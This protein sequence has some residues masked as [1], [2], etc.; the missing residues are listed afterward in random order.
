MMPEEPNQE[1][2]RTH[3]RGWW[4]P[5]EIVELLQNGKINA[6]EMALL[7][8]ID[9]L[10]SKTRGCFASREYLAEKLGTSP[11]RISRMISHLKKLG[12]VIQTKFDGRV[13]E[14]ETIW[15]RVK[16][17]T[18]PR[19]KPQGGIDENPKGDSGETPRR[20]R[21]DKKSEQESKDCRNQ[22]CD[23]TDKCSDF[24]RRIAEKLWQSVGDETT[25]SR[26]VNCNSKINSW[27]DHVRRLR[28]VDGHS[29]ETIESV[30]RWYLD[31]GREFVNGGGYVVQSG[32]A[33]RAK[34]DAMLINMRR[35][36]GRPSEKSKNADF[37]RRCREIGVTLSDGEILG[38]CRDW[39][40]NM[41]VTPKYVL[42]L[43]REY[44]ED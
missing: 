22:G 26:K 8:T 23:S 39:G 15:S 31:V 27:A 37:I 28:Q 18:Q 14:M 11:D 30:L 24:D 21:V 33:F 44:E 7:A 20:N 36:N 34:F 41:E 9:S 17:P 6:L 2:P 13:R 1:K 16:I 3:C 35:Q 4:I 43:Q 29:E 5:I 10:V 40:D 38:I 32:K 42:R 25:G 12:F 19:R